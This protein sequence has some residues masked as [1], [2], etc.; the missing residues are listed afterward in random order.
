MHAAREG[1]KPDAVREQGG[2][3]DRE[4]TA[5]AAAGLETGASPTVQLRL[6]TTIQAKAGSTPALGHTPSRAMRRDERSRGT[7]RW[8]RLIMAIILS[9]A[10][11]PGST[12]LS[13]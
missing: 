12:R 2:R 11:D 1:A 6:G 10:A 8:I 7:S 9:L 3:A 13:P 5:A 4:G